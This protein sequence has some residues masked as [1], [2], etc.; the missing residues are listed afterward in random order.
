MARFT[1]DNALPLRLLRKLFLLPQPAPRK[2]HSLL[3]LYT[4]IMAIYIYIYIYTH[5]CLCVCMYV[6]FMQSALF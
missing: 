5:I 3:E 1:I 6:F 2:V 4:A